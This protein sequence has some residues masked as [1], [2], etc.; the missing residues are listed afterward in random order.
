M[1]PPGQHPDKLI[2]VVP[3]AD[4]VPPRV[5]DDGDREIEEGDEEVG[6]ERGEPCWSSSQER[7]SVPAT[8]SR[9]SGLRLVLAQGRGRPRTNRLMQFTAAL[10]AY[11]IQAGDSAGV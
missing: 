10:G 6:T 9:R 11:L 8:A 4:Q 1:R 7:G 3:N 5:R 2:R